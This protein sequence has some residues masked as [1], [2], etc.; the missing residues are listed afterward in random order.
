MRIKISSKIKEYIVI[1]VVIGMVFGADI[2]QSGSAKIYADDIAVE[3]STEHIDENATEE[4]VTVGTITEEKTTEK[5]PEDVTENYSEEITEK[6]TTEPI[7]EKQTTEVTTVKEQTTKNKQEKKQKKKQIK[8]KKP[9]GKWKTKKGYVYYIRPNKKKTKGFIKIKNK[10]YYFDKK[11]IQKNGWQKIG[12]NYYF[13]KED[14]GKKGYM[15]TSKKINGIKLKK[16]GRAKLTAY[17]KKKLN[18]LI[19]AQKIIEKCT[20]PTMKKYTKLKKVYQYAL[21]NFQFRGSPTFHYSSDWDIRYALQMFDD[22]HG[23]CYAYGGAFAYLANAVGYHDSY[24][25]SSGGHGWAQAKGHVFDV[26]WENADSHSYFDMDYSYSGIGGRPNYAKNK[27]YM[28][29]I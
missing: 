9:E 29:R 8:K 28:K 23:A 20:K 7:T 4:I 5:N 10:K 15:V 17:A 24:I 3:V 14:G 22:G 26:S 6:Q 12:G 25:V 18:P 2:S 21:K 13:F 1:M 16:N 19:K 27:K 11:G